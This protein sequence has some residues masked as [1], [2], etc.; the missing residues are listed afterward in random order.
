M[1]INPRTLNTIAD[2]VLQQAQL[3]AFGPDPV[4]TVA[5][6]VVYAT[7]ADRAQVVELIRG[8]ARR[9]PD[10]TILVRLPT[11]RPRD[12]INPQPPFAVIRGP[13]GMDALARWAAGQLNAAPSDAALASKR[14]GGDYG[15]L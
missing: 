9:E 11:G 13:A 6:Q 4:A 3:A 5:D 12:P 14:A 2:E 15:V 7:G 8:K 1:P 10:G